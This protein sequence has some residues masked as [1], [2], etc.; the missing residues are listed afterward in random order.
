MLPLRELGDRLGVH[1]ERVSILEAAFVAQATRLFFDRYRRVCTLPTV[2]WRTLVLEKQH[3]NDALH[4]VHCRT[5][6]S[7]VS[8]GLFKHGTFAW[9]YQYIWIV[10]TDTPAAAIR[11]MAIRNRDTK[12]PRKN[13]TNQTK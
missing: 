1:G 3:E 6:N 4:L 13:N 7:M 5:S 2:A 9:D 12:H 11:K 8:M 10:G